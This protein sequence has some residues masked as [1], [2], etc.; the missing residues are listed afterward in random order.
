MIGC[1]GLG[2]PASYYLSGAG[3]GTLGLVDADVVEE[4][5]LHRQ[6]IHT[7]ARVNINKTES[8]KTSINAFNRHTNVITY[9]HKFTNETAEEIVN[10][11]KWD[12]VMDGS[13]NPKTRYL[14]NDICM[15]KKLPLVSGSA[16]KWEG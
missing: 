12:V 7:E 10:S 16:L 14:V 6:I 1:G 13:D 9:P 3:V 8:A 2:S 5:N 15:I 4:S 11:Q